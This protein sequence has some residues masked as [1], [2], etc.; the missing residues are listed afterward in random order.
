VAYGGLTMLEMIE[1]DRHE[2]LLDSIRWSFDYA[3][4]T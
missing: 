1:Q 4:T 2:E 3:V